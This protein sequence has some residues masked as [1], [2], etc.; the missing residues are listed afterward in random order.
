M[1]V[2]VKLHQVIQVDGELEKDLG[3]E[4]IDSNQRFQMSM[5][6]SPPRMQFVDTLEKGTELQWDATT[7]N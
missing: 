1:L 4:L 3:G 5:G 7:L 2:L 6:S